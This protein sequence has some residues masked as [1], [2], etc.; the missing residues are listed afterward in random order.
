MDT[1]LNTLV[2]VR[3]LLLAGWAFNFVGVYLGL[4][5]ASTDKKWETSLLHILGAGVLASIYVGLFY[6]L[7]IVESGR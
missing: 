6:L 5:I 7:F 4:E 3:D 2:T 1:T